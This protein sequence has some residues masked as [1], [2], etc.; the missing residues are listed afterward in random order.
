M[1]V[2]GT[3][4]PRCASHGGVAA[5]PGAPIGNQNAVT[6]GLYAK[7]WNSARGVEKFALDEAGSLANAAAVSE[8]S[9]HTITLVTRRL[10]DN[11]LVLSDY[12]DLQAEELPL[13]VLSHLLALHAQM[14]S[15][16][17]RLARDLRIVVPEQDGI[18]M[19]IEQAMVELSEILGTDLT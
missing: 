13:A 12:I 18:S 19:A 7:G 3:D 1:A 6:H 9:R 5:K 16:L 11:Y 17:G 4:P 14:A 15:R 2:P 8:E 10:L